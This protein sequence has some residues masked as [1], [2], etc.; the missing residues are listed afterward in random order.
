MTDEPVRPWD[1]RAVRALVPRV[2]AGLVRRGEDFGAAGPSGSL[3]ARVERAAR[4][5]A[6]AVLGRPRSGP[7]DPFADPTPFEQLLGGAS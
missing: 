5:L 6:D 7:V 4:E 1:E 3:S 2:L